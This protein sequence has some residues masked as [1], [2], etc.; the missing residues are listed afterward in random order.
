MPTEKEITVSGQK[1][2]EIADILNATN[3]KILKEIRHEPLYITTISK[4]LGL[5]EAYISEQIKALEDLKLVSVT[6]QRGDRGIRK[7][8]ASAIE[9]ITIIIKDEIPTPS[10]L[11][12]EKSI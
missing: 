8:C 2:L 9:K 4:K 5:S 1:A 6:Y 12:E 3:L 11:T 7:I 10:N